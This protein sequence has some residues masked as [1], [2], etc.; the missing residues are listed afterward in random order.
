[1]PKRIL[2][3]YHEAMGRLSISEDAE[4]ES[5]RR[6]IIRSEFN[7]Q[8]AS[9]ETLAK[10][11]ERDEDW[12]AR[13]FD[14]LRMTRFIVTD[15]AEFVW[16]RPTTSRLDDIMAQLAAMETTAIVRLS[17]MECA[18]AIPTIRRLANE[19]IALADG[20]DTIAASLANQRLMLGI[21]SATHQHRLIED[22]VKL[23][24]PANA[25]AAA[26]RRGEPELRCMKRSAD[27]VARLI[28]KRSVQDC[29]AEAVAMR[30][31]PMQPVLT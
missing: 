13:A 8:G 1:M 29:A 17:A 11:A 12:A 19:F 28:G 14:D 24:S 20:E 3:L 4:I 23:A 5:I 16:Y 21:V 22:Y 27:A 31:H 6:R 18:P 25:Y 26:S 15:W 7:D 10:I 2:Q 9:P 30:L